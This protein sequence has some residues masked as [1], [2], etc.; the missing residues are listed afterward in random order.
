MTTNLKLIRAMDAKSQR[1][2]QELKDKQL[3]V[4]VLG[5][6][7]TDTELNELRALSAR[8]WDEEQKP[9]PFTA[10][11]YP[12]VPI[13]KKIQAIDAIIKKASKEE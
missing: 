11:L 10:K 4:E 13:I 8:E 9:D 2:L 12:K 3:R 7:L 6:K 5:G 1:R